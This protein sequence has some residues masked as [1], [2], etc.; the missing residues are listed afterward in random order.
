[1]KTVI[2]LRRYVDNLTSSELDLFRAAFPGEE[3]KFKRTDPHT[4]I[5][6]LADCERIKPDAIMLPIE[7]PIPSAAME[8]GFRHVTVIDG[9]LV[10]LQKINTEFVPFTP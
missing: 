2:L 7:R 8:K 1:M 9:K 4:F 10:Q 3:I 6:H 5:D